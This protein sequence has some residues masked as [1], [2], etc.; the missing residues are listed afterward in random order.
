MTNNFQILLFAR[1]MAGLFGTAYGVIATTTI[2]SLSSNKNVGRNIALLISGASAALMIGIPLCRILIEYFS[3]QMIYLVLVILMGGGLLAYTILLPESKTNTVKI[4]L[5][6]EWKLLTTPKV[7]SIILASFIVFVGYGAFYT[8]LTPYLIELF[9]QIE[10]YTSGILVFV[11]A[12]ALIGNSISG[13]I[14]DRIGFARALLYGTE[15][16]ILVGFLI[17]ITQNNMVVNILYV[18]LWMITGWFIG[19]QL[20][21][22]INVVSQKRSNFIVSLSGSI[23]QFSQAVG[24]S[25]SAIV[26]NQFGMP[27]IIFISMITSLLCVIFCLLQT[28]QKQA[29]IITSENI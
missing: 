27:M 9:P 7:W 10:P 22:G 19:L 13:Y 25:I 17:F 11:G 14:C 28:I 2:A 26:I 4:D 1:F 23:I 29:A 12:C 20:N 5:N 3:W 18:F 21:T 16:Q 6:K 15:L 8:Y 24:A